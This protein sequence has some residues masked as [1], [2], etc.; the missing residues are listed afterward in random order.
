MALA[1]GKTQ[2]GHLFLS[3]NYVSAAL[4]TSG[5]QHS[6]WSEFRQFMIAKVCGFDREEPA[7]ILF[8]SPLFP[9]DDE[10]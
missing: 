5:L 10:P 2:A 8:V 4:H 9:L 3:R 1:E 7:Q 6:R